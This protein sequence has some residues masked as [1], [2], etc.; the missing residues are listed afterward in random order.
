[1]KVD[2]LHDLL[3]RINVSQAADQKWNLTLPARSMGLLT[4]KRQ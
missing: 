4:F 3:G 2:Q 1:M